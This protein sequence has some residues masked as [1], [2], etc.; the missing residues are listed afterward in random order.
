MGDGKL[1]CAWCPEFRPEASIGTTISHGICPECHAK[2]NAQ[3][4][5]IEVKDGHN[6]RNGGMQLVRLPLPPGD[7]D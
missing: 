7:A 2:M 5:A 6:R 4:G 1:T 3:L